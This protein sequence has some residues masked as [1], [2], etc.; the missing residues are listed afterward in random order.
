MLFENTKNIIELNN[1]CMMADSKN[2]NSQSSNG[3]TFLLAS[4]GELSA[5]EGLDFH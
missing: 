4:Q 1:Q 3:A 5:E 2:T